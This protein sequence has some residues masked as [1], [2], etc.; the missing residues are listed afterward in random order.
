M[1]HA[2][3]IG[4]VGALAVALGVGVAA[5]TG[6]GIGSPAAAW[7]EEGSQSSGGRIGHSR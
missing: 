6:Y 7:A 5:A 1:G 4:R 3:Y 2:I